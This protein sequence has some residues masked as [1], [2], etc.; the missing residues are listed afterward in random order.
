MSFITQNTFN[1]HQ[2]KGQVGHNSR[3]ALPFELDNNGYIAGE[4]L[5]PGYAVY[6]SEHGFY[7]IPPIKHELSTIGVVHYRPQSINTRYAKR[8]DNNPGEIIIKMGDPFEVMLAGHIYVCVGEKVQK[9]LPAMFDKDKKLWK[10]V[11]DSDGSTPLFNNPMFFEENGEAG[12][13]VSLRIN[14]QIAKAKV[15]K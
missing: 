11:P 15:S 1:I 5:K 6:K 14:G 4:D 7:E 8:T 9:G 12:D 3:P 2:S 13:I 10:A